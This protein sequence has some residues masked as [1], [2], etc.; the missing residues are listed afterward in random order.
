MTVEKCGNERMSL[1]RLW[2]PINHEKKDKVNQNTF[3][4]NMNRKKKMRADNNYYA[5][6]LKNGGNETEKETEWVQVMNRDIEKL[7]E[8]RFTVQER[9]QIKKKWS[10]EMKDCVD[11]EQSREDDGREFSSLTSRVSVRCGNHCRPLMSLCRCMCRC[12]LTR[13]ERCAEFHWHPVAVEAET[14]G[15]SPDRPSPKQTWKYTQTT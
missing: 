5:F 15:R 14:E 13:S 7:N 11:R 9:E 12:H 10:E 3:K 2:L 6:K 8:V 1:K 4:K